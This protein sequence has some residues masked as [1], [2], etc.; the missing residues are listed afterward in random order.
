MLELSKDIQFVQGDCLQG[1]LQIVNESVDTIYLDPPFDSNRIY[2]LSSESDVG[3]NDKWKEEN[4][5]A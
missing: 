3:F 1:L 5:V 4:D 2:K